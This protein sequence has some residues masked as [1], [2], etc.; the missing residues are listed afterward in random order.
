MTDFL[1]AMLIP[2]LVISS[3]DR[4]VVATSQ[5]GAEYRII[6]HKVLQK[7]EIDYLKMCGLHGKVQ[8]LHTFG[9]IQDTITFDASF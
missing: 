4:P 2:S 3:L 6:W 5:I 7:L 9:T 8:K 1:V